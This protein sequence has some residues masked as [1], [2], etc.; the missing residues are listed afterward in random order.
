MCTFSP[1]HMKYCYYVMHWRVHNS[2][3]FYPGRKS[4][5]VASLFYLS[6]PQSYLD[7]H[8]NPIHETF[9]KAY[10]I[11][12]LAFIHKE[13]HT[14]QT[15][16]IPHTWLWS[17]GTGCLCY[18]YEKFQNGFKIKIL[19]VWKMYVLIESSTSLG[20]VIRFVLF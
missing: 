18:N 4:T 14:Y 17:L 12:Y 3:C 1:L 2:V 13:N 20:I 9:N 8:N 7:K 5:L 11:K 19:V 16:S 10:I 6:N 15:K